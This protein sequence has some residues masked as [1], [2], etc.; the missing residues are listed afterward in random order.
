[1][2]GFLRP[3]ARYAAPIACRNLTGDVEMFP[4]ALGLSFPRGDRPTPMTLIVGSTAFRASYEL[5]SSAWYA[6]PE[7]FRPRESNCGC[8]NRGWFGSFP[9]MTF[10]TVG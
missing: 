5:A 7:T 8:Q 6:A 1:M 3:L 10:L 2:S 9:T 4:E